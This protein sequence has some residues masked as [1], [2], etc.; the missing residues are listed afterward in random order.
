M[1]PKASIYSLVFQRCASC[2]CIYCSG[3]SSGNVLFLSSPLALFLSFALLSFFALSF[4]L[5]LYVSSLAP[6]WSLIEHHLDPISSFSILILFLSISR[7]MAL[8][9]RSDLE[10]F[11][12]LVLLLLNLLADV[13]FVSRIQVVRPKVLQLSRQVATAHLR[14]V[15]VLRKLSFKRERERGERQRG[16]ERKRWRQERERGE[17]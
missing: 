4:L 13:W 10:F 12:L 11:E 9:S 14:L 2:N 8:K 17:R 5:F 7:P 1:A 3:F 15:S 16:R 6:Q